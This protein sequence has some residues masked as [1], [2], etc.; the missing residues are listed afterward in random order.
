MII[1]GDNTSTWGY[2]PGATANG[3]NA[4]DYSSDFCVLAWV[5]APGSDPSENLNVWEFQ[6]SSATWGVRCFFSQG[7]D[8]FQLRCNGSSAALVANVSWDFGAAKSGDLGKWHLVGMSFN[9]TSKSATLMVMAEGDVA[10]T[11]DSDT[12]AAGQDFGTQAQFAGGTEG[13]QKAW[14]RHGLLVVR[15]HEMSAA[16]FAAIFAAGYGAPVDYATGNFNGV[17]GVQWMVS[18]ALMGSPATGPGQSTTAIEAM[19]GDT[20]VAG[21]GA[22]NCN[23]IIFDRTRDADQR[24]VWDAAV[25]GGT[26]SAFGDPF[27]EDAFT[28]DDASTLATGVPVAGQ[29]DAMQRL[30]TSGPVGRHLIIC[31]G[32][33]RSTRVNVDD[34]YG[35]D[36]GQCTPAGLSAYLDQVRGSQLVGCCVPAHS[37]SAFACWPYVQTSSPHKSGTVATIGTGTGTYEDF[38]KIGSGNNNAS[39]SAMGQHVHLA[40]SSVFQAVFDVVGHCDFD[41]TTD[42][43][44]VFAVMPVFPGGGDVTVEATKTTGIGTNGTLVGSATTADQD[45]ERTTGTVVSW[46][47]GSKSLVIDETG[48]NITAGELVYVD[49]GTGAGTLFQSN[50]NGLEGDGNTTITT[51]HGAN[52]APVASD[53]V[54]I[55]NLSWEVVTR[56]IPAGSLGLTD[57]AGIRF[58][59]GSGNGLGIVSMVGCYVANKGGFVPVVFGHSGHGFGLQYAETFRKNDSTGRNPFGKLLRAITGHFTGCRHAYCMHG[60]S[61]SSTTADFGTWTDMVQAQSIERLDISWCIEGTNPGNNETFADDSDGSDYGDYAGDNA[62]A[63][64]V[65]AVASQVAGG[66]PSGLDALMRGYYANSGNHYSTLGNVKLWE[67]WLSDDHG[68]AAWKVAQEAGSSPFML[69]RRVI[70]RR[71]GLEQ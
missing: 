38:A 67:H 66:L 25:T 1:S 22:G 70:P 60:A 16:E 69:R 24:N 45:G 23:L 2:D 34:Y 5:K 37:T 13:A 62:T 65:S 39:G 31:H 7:N 32:N 12:V 43:L 54:S 19:P 44:V 27:D 11:T 56:T 4:I 10:A 53:T 40:A 41:R 47:A 18:H 61:Q 63:Q 48:R 59:T 15:N 20:L 30:R 57:Y 9:G 17:T 71:R 64:G 26:A 6:N 8:D 50:S 36:S 28:P 29:A 33:S 21:G 3:L 58:T 42:D 14:P 68:G 51:T 55:G 46:T 52:T 49:T 35:D